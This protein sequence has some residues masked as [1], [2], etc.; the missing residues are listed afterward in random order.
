MK[1]CGTPDWA[2]AFGGLS[3]AINGF[4]ALAGSTVPSSVNAITLI[5]SALIMS[6][7][8]LQNYLYGMKLAIIV[9]FFHILG[10]PVTNFKS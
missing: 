2:E 8:E 9:G 6:L 4:W 3:F 10:D 5:I 1:G 7:L